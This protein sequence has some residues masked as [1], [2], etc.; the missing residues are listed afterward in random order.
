MKV[1]C[2]QCRSEFD[3][4][5]S[6]IKRNEEDGYKHYCSYEC[7]HLG[8]RNRIT[9]ICVIC[10][11]QMMVPTSQAYRYST[12]SH[13]CQRVYRSNEG[14]SN[15]R[16]GKMNT[17]LRLKEMSKLEYKTWRKAIFERDDYAC[18]F[19]HK[20]GGDLEADHIKPWS[21]FPKLRYELTNGRTLCLKCHRTTFKNLKNG[22]SI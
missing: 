5:P 15:W 17:K 12:C 3:K 8:K 13:E 20:H 22:S 2:N 6:L 19:C 21:K 7:S 4:R 10:G 18:Q 1:I 9:K 14:N 11:N 16:G